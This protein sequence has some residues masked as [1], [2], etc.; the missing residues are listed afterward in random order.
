MMNVPKPSTVAM[1]N[2]MHATYGSWRAVAREYEYPPSFAAT[3]SGVAAEKP[4]C[5]SH[6]RE[7]ELRRRM[8]FVDVQTTEV[9]VCPT[10]GKVHHLPDCD[11]K[12]GEL[13]YIAKPHTAPR[14]RLHRPVASNEHEAR[15]QRLGVTWADVHEAGLRALEQEQAK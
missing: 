8:G 11:G 10:C 1:L 4:G 12:D 13:R 6:Q 7:L 3:L 2:D 14:R 15:R 9:E 5:I